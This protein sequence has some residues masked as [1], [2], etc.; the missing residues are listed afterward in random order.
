MSDTETER[1]LRAELR[2][3]Q[4]QVHTAAAER[5]ETEAALLE[6]R[7]ATL[8]ANARA[9]RAQAEATASH[10]AVAQIRRLCDLTINASC[11]TQAIEQAQDTLAVL[12]AITPDKA[13]PGDAA[14]HSVWLHGDWRWLTKNMTTAEREHAADAVQRYSTHLEPDEPD[15]DGLRWWRE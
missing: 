7:A 1:R 10:L 13:L 15:I 12:D 5:A 14:W 9:S 8:R 11:R 6:A 3:A 4:Q 2:I